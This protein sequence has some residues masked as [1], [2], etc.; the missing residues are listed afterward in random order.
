MKKFVITIVAFVG[1]A[2]AVA[3]NTD[4][5]TV[6]KAP[7]DLFS[8]DKGAEGYTL[9]AVEIFSSRQTISVIR[10]SPKR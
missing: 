6:V 5:L 7:R 8:L 1:A 10:Y 9:K 3:Q 2:T 4:S